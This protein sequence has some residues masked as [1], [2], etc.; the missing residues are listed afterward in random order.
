M[1]VLI[2]I[3]VVRDRREK[4]YSIGLIPIGLGGGFLDALGG[5]GWGDGHL[6]AGGQG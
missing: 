2:L 1:A 3:R 5:G 4:S 6:D